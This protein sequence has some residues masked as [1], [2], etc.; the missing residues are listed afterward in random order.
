M[1]GPKTE[2]NMNSEILVVVSS[3][4][5]TSDE[6]VFTN[7][8]RKT[9]CDQIDS[10]D[11]EDQN[12][13]AKKRK[14]EEDCL[15]RQ[16]V[17]VLNGNWDSRQTISKNTADTRSIKIYALD[18]NELCIPLSESGVTEITVEDINSIFKQVSERASCTDLNTVFSES[19]PLT[20][21]SDTEYKHI[22]DTENNCDYNLSWLINFKV[23]ALFNADEVK[24]D[25]NYKERE[26][27]EITCPGM[28]SKCSNHSFSVLH[29]LNFI[30]TDSTEQ[31]LLCANGSFLHINIFPVFMRTYP[32]PSSQMLPV[33]SNL[34]LQNAF[35]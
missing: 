10:M 24:H 12:A 33:R 1:I 2:E 18:G 25:H 4:T 6:E 32:F 16:E 5:N 27:E 19:I 23:G 28:C 35:L 17:L 7:T 22:N 11:N 30:L 26:V 20:E 34:H 29:S 15:K 14:T 13:C 21:H 9:F 8:E 3:K 31:S